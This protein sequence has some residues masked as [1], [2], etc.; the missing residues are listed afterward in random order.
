MISFCFPSLSFAKEKMAV[1]E[2]KPTHGVQE[3]LAKALSVEVRNAIHSQGEYEVIS[4]EDLAAIAERTRM[5]QSLGCDDTRCLIDFGQAIGTRFMIAGSVSKLGE[6]YSVDLRLI[7]TEGPE[8]GVKN[9]A[10]KKCACP[11]SK[12]FGTATAVA[13]LVMGKEDPQLQGGEIAPAPQKDIEGSWLF[14][15]NGQ[16]WVNVNFNRKDEN[17]VGEVVRIHRR[18]KSGKKW[19][20]FAIDSISFEEERIIVACA[21]MSSQGRLPPRI[22]ILRATDD[23]GLEGFFEDSPDGRI[24]GTRKQEE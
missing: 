22:M 14:K 12:L 11:E 3:S 6:T 13:A 18:P 15:N 17:L 5:R 7:D 19:M 23:G 10:S 16:N 8:A 1:M 4:K 2:L 9:R 21:F 20:N 24:I